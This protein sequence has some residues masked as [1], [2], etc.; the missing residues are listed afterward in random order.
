M[1]SALH[2]APGEKGQ[3]VS[4]KYF[5]SITKIFYPKEAFL[6]QTLDAHNFLMI[7]TCENVK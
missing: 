4:Q 2:C 3:G 7:C 1:H 5:I 6:E